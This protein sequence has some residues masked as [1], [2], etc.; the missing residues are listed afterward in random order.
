MASINKDLKRLER[1]EQVRKHL[2][3]IITTVV[4]VIAALIT[5]VVIRV[6][7][8]KA[9]AVRAAE[10]AARAEEEAR[11]AAEEAARLAAE[12]ASR[13][14]FPEDP[15]Y[16][17]KV[18][19]LS[20]GDNLIHESLYRDAETEDGYDFR[21]MYELV[22]DDIRAADV[23][24][25]NMETPIA[26][27]IA[28]IS[29]YP[30]F[31]TPHE[32]GDALI[33]AGFDVINQGNNHVLDMGVS[34]LYATLDYWD[35]EG[36][37]YV[38]AYRDMDDLLTRRIVERN[39]VK[40]AFLSFV[41]TSMNNE[42]VPE[43]EGYEILTFFDESMMEDL[44]AD[45]RENADVVV[46]HV[47][48]GV[49]DEDIITDQM[50]DMAQKMVDWGVDIIFGNHTHVL[51]ELRVL[52]RAED[53]AY[54]PVLFSGGNFLSGQQS[55]DHLIS[56][57]MTVTAARNP[58]T[59][60]TQIQKVA[61]RPIIT[62]YEGDRENV[63]IYPVDEYTEELA[64]EHGV[65]LEDEPLTMDFINRTVEAHISSQFLKE[66]VPQKEQKETVSLTGEEAGEETGEEAE[67]AEAEEAASSEEES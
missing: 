59:G 45:A 32:A 3:I 51:Q 13:I 2:I 39:G 40:V 43:N 4:L 28:A 23:A 17:E 55:R 37:P 64:A 8:K 53:G 47:H 1:E 54:C 44:I 24:T 30:S 56:G 25:V 52:Q 49:E 29:G 50:N 9:E 20:T 35:E 58:E 21:P 22:R 31:N 15:S 46:A 34:G 42:N 26:D 62:H 19:I 33:D 7:V 65:K 14:H 5:A 57:L 16:T 18:T 63:K 67:E 11:L 41:Q 6:R 48:W 38:G 36:I 61:F 10:E 12:E 27:S 66:G 60:D